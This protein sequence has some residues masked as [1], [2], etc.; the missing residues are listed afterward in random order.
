[1]KS[2]TLQSP[3]SCRPFPWF[4]DILCLRYLSIKTGGGSTDSKL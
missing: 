3:F 1:M 2:I 4:A